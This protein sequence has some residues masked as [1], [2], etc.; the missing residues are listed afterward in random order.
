VLGGL[1]TTQEIQV[2]E[3]VPGLGSIP[4]LGFLFTNIHT[5]E[6]RSNLLFFL[7]P[8]ILNPAGTRD[9]DIILPPEEGESIGPSPDVIVP[10]APEPEKD[11]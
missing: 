10:P 6:S 4:V 7:R 2:E 8:R 3:R 11:R 5:R 9:V 1:L